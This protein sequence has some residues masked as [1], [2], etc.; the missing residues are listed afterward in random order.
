MHKIVLYVL[1]FL[2]F[3][4]ILVFVYPT[5]YVYDKIDQKWPV[6]INR[7]TGKTEVLYLDGWY[8]LGIYEDEPAETSVVEEET[9]TEVSKPKIS[10]ERIEL[11]S[12]LVPSDTKEVTIEDFT[13]TKLHVTERNI[14]GIIFTDSDEDRSLASIQ[15]EL[16]DKEGNVLPYQPDRKIIGLKP[17]GN[18]VF[19][20]PTSYSQNSIGSFRIKL[21]YTA[22]K[23]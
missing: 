3:C 1:S 18:E 2:A 13:I 8:T 23:E 5:L 12:D 20:Y 9:S 11:E 14:T 17:K 10:I 16:Y 7:I 6:R 15:F 22:I 19:T 21:S 4:L